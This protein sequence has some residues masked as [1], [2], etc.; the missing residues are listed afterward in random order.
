[1]L[2]SFN[3][4]CILGLTLYGFAL[5]LKA[6][7]DFWIGGSGAD[8]GTMKLLGTAYS[9]LYPDVTVKVM[10][11]LG[12]TGAIKALKAS[13]LDL[14]TTSRPL[15]TSEKTPLIQSALYAY[16]PF[17]FVATP[18]YAQQTVSVAQLQ[19]IYD[20]SH[21]YWP[22]GRASRAI[23]R[24]DNDSDPR[25]LKASLEGFSETLIKAYQRRVKLVAFTDQESADY[26]ERIPGALGTSVLSLIKSEERNLKPLDL[27][28]V[29]P[30]VENM[31][32]SRYKMKKNLY[33]VFSAQ[34]SMQLKRFLSFVKSTKAQQILLE[35]GHE[36]V[37]FNME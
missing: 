33:F 20:G 27:E 6:A 7:T 36:T 1:M 28:G 15:K 31:K 16:T 37:P 29:E 34:P 8:L 30:T 24:P 5:P 4:M 19:K 12:S 21:P 10:P 23:L 17:I 32:N 11:S 2:K 25:I 13:R 26:V 18:S 35:T 9:E 3:A 22:D 14:A